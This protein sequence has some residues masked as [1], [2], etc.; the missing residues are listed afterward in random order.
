MENEDNIE[1]AQCPSARAA[2]RRGQT[3]LWPRRIQL[4]RHGLLARAR[5]VHIDIDRPKDE[6]DILS[7]LYSSGGKKHSTS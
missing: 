2:H 3:R 6:G 7:S 4:L 1:Q 5:S